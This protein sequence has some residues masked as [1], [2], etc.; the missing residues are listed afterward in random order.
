[1]AKKDKQKD[2]M[3]TVHWDVNGGGVFD[4]INIAPPSVMMVPAEIV[5]QLDDEDVSNAVADWL[6]DETGFFVFTWSEVTH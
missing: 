4:D 5:A 1:M 2:M 6:S 3:V